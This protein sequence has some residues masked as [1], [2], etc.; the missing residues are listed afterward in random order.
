MSSP[1]NNALP[2]SAVTAD[3]SADA[4]LD[5]HMAL[6]RKDIHSIKKD[7]ISTN[8]SLTEGEATG[9]WPLLRAIFRELRQDHGDADRT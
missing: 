2:Q 6:L 7:F 5:L 3:S 4:F 1:R 9:F 8:L